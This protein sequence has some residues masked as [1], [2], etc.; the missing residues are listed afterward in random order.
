MRHSSWIVLAVA[1]TGLLLAPVSVAAQSPRYVVEDLGLHRGAAPFAMAINDHGEVAGYVFVDWQIQPVRYRDGHGLQI[2]P[3]LESASGQATGINSLGEIAG[4]VVDTE[5]SW[6]A[7]RLRHG[8]GLEPLGALGGSASF[9]MQINASGSVA[10]YSYLAGDAATRAF[11][12]A[13]GAPLRNL[14]TLGGSTSIACGI[15]DAG[16][17]AGRSTTAGE[18]QRAFRYT[19][20]AG[21][22]DLGTLGGTQSIACGINASGA[23]AGRAQVAGNAAWHAFR[24]TATNGM[25]DLDTR[26][27]ALSAAEGINDAGAVVGWFVGPTGS[28]AFIFEDGEMVDLN[29]LIDPASGWQLTLA[30]DVNNE[31]QVIGQGIH[32]GESRAFRLTP[33]ADP[34]DTEPPVI[35]RAAADR[36][37]LWPANGAMV[38]VQVEVS[39]TDNVDAWPTCRIADVTSTENAAA[40]DVRLTG[41]LSVELRARRSGI[42]TGR[43][44]TIGIV[45][46]DAAGNAA[47]AAVHVHVPHDQSGTGPSTAALGRS[48]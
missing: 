42:G 5:G 8:S 44:Y 2:L 10:G 30:R 18:I 40:A 3:G 46:E 43:T 9:G 4:S 24:H 22:A 15:N 6:Q 31:G 26:G 21:M 13:P 14:G 38:P 11:V 20:E 35:H 39:V 41:D 16:Q 36:D 12:A 17:V 1:L 23:V 47:E 29:D 48:R 7:F 27:S 33:L 34:A 25:E 28:R 37:L 32:L 45:C 19:P